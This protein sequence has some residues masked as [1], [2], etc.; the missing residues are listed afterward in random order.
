MPFATLNPT[1]PGWEVYSGGV[2]NPQK[3]LHIKETDQRFVLNGKALENLLS[4]VKTGESVTVSGTIAGFR[5]KHLPV[6]VIEDFTPG[7]RN[8]A[9]SERTGGTETAAKGA[10]KSEA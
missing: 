1:Y 4:T 5:E 9:K 6:L 10:A 2:L 3:V 8:L 7:V